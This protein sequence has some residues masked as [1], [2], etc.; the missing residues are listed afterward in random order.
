MNSD[1]GRHS[2]DLNAPAAIAQDGPPLSRWRKF[3]LVVKVVELRLRFVALM[4][5]TALVFAYWDEI[6]NRYEKWMRPA[7]RR[8]RGDFGHRV[9]LP[10]ASAGRAGRSRHLPD[11]R[12]AARE[13]EEGREGDSARRGHRPRR[14][15]ARSAWP[16]PASRPRRW[17]T[18][19]CVQTLN[20]R[21]ICRIRR[22]ADWPTS[23]PRFRAS[24]GSRSCTSISPAR[25]SKPARRWPSSTALS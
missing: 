14:A 19:R 1:N 18:H 3:R 16:R 8:A 24:R 13:A 9:L 12:H 15:G 10:D 21:R 6:W 7:A 25:T 20:D 11:L 23:S 5:A 2:A 17:R 22:A 4:A